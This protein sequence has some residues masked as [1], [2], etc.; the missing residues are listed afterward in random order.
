MVNDIYFFPGAVLQVE[1]GRPVSAL[2]LGAGNHRPLFAQDVKFNAQLRYR[3]EFD[4]N[5]GSFNNANFQNAV[6]GNNFELLRTRLGMLL[7]GGN[8]ITAFIQVQ[9]ARRYGEEFYTTE[10]KADKFDLHQQNLLHLHLI[11]R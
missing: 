10:G 9:D 5:G 1:P 3:A 11:Q 6:A 2:S 4:K 7:D 8:D